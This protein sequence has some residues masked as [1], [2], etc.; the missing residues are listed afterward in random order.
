M[1]STGSLSCRWDTACTSK[2]PEGKQN[3]PQRRA[4]DES[5][6]SDTE[7]EESDYG[8]FM[9]LMDDGSELV[10]GGEDRTPFASSLEWRNQG[11]LPSSRAA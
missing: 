5:F 6:R 1:A 4:D 10:I 8:E 11:P 3:F 9:F 2:S 7:V